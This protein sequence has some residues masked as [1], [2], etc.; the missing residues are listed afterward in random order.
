MTINTV[1]MQ[2]CKSLKLDCFE[3]F[4]SFLVHAW[5]LAMDIDFANQ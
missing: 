4:F 2:E 3:P 5:P 1:F